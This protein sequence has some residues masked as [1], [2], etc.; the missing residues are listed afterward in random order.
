[1]Y[2]VTLET[3]YSLSSFCPAVAPSL[4]SFLSLAYLALSLLFAD[5]STLTSL[6]LRIIINPKP[7][8]DNPNRS[9]FFFFLIQSRSFL[10]SLMRSLARLSLASRC[11][12]ASR[13]DF[14]SD[15]FHAL[16][17]P[18]V[19]NLSATIC[20]LESKLDHA[21]S[22][23]SPTILRIATSLPENFKR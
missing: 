5:S 8:T 13:T 20:F 2:I 12:D 19:K 14:L 10:Y 7:I 3:W 6:S 15:T 4:P 9:R 11:L 16:F 21:R 22:S 17:V 23:R 1:M 18:A